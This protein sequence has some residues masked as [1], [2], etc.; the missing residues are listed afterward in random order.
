ML[1]LTNRLA[2]S[3]NRDNLLST[4]AK[5]P[6]AAHGS[7]GATGRASAFQ[8]QLLF[9][10]RCY[11]ASTRCGTLATVLPTGHGLAFDTRGLLSVSLRSV[12]SRGSSDGSVASELSLRHI[13]DGSPDRASFD[14]RGLR[15]IP[16]CG[17]SRQLR[18]QCC[19]QTL[20]AAH[21]RRFSRPG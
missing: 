13:G 19:E 16:E 6:S 17:K 20:A 4:Q 8:R 9:R 15:V 11:R 14:T 10:W 2:Q 1:Q 7:G 21:W 18:W 3:Q 5:L 12:G